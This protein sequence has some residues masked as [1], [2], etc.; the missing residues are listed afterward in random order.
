MECAGYINQSLAGSARS[1]G[2]L[3]VY[4]FVGLSAMMAQ[5][6]GDT[7]GESLPTGW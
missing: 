4:H 6:E 2:C 7:T 1:I 3:F 5:A